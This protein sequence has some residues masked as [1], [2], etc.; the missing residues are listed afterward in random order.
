MRR[1][2]ITIPQPTSLAVAFAIVLAAN[3]GAPAVGAAAGMADTARVH[4]GNRTPTTCPGAKLSQV[5]VSP[6]PGTPEA[7]PQ[8]QVSFLGVRAAQLR[9]VNVIGSRTGRHS[10]RLRSYDSA[11][12]ASFISNSPFA[13][14]EQVNVCATVRT[15][16]GPRPI[17]TSFRVASPA[18]LKYEAPFEIPGTRGDA[19]AY[20]SVDL[21]PP[22]VD[23]THQAGPRS[24]PGDIFLTPYAGP[25]EHG[26][27]IFESSGELVWFHRPPNPDWGIADLRPQVWQGHDDLLWWQGLINT[28]GFGTGED[29]IANSAYEPVA[30]IKGGNGLPADLHDVQ[31]TSSGA[32]Y[33]TVYYPVWTDVPV[34][35]SNG[36]VRRAVVLDSAVQEIDVRTG[37]VMWEWQSLGHVP[38]S[39][40]RIKAPS[41]GPYDYFHLDSLQVLPEGKLLICA[42]NV[43]GIY[44]IAPH[45]GQ[46]AWQL[47]TRQSSLQLASG[48]RFGWPEEAQLLPGG[49]LALYDGGAQS[50]SHPRGEVLDL[51]WSNNT[52]SLAPYGQLPGSFGTPREVGQGSI[53][54]LAQGNWLLGF[55]GLPSLTEFDSE[56][57]VI[58]EARFPAGEVGYRVYR[59]PWQG[60]PTAAPNLLADNSGAGT[61]SYMSFD[62]ATDVASWR[63]FG[64]SSAHTL[65]ALATAPAA[66]FETAI[67]T[68]GVTDVLAQ[69]LNAAGEV[70]G[71][72]KV[73]PT[74]GG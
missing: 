27:M 55:G 56:G 71:E 29:V 61:T 18:R 25:A 69:A 1:R 74:G 20:H 43:W 60:Q 73:I 46:I 63:L 57:N 59:A 30:R 4:A 54:P 10:G 50:V 52:A 38:L 23:V 40:S 12:G 44:A 19:Q 8:T 33:I 24:A 68:R 6:L 45:T 41:S 2:S 15:A 48:V 65:E 17:A 16:K 47:G 21:K 11:T 26:A 62:G 49:Q 32:A 13:A 67:T 3:F 34:P 72:S 64:G 53:Q 70:I 66:G 37:L 5:T 22:K 35:G 39:Q 36:A 14:G 7:S 51:E 9:S 31:L 28:F 42:R 58:Y